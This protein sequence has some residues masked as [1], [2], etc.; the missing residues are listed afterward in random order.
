MLSEIRHR[1]EP[2]AASL[3]HPCGK[4]VKDRAWVAAKRRVGRLLPAGFA[5]FAAQW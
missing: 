3:A 1:P 5:R 4:K 2:G